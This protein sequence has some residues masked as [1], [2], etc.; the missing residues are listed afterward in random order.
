MSEESAQPSA[1]SFV[2]WVVR[3]PQGVEALLVS[4]VYVAIV[5]VKN[6]SHITDLIPEYKPNQQFYESLPSAFQCLALA[7]ALWLFMKVRGPDALSEKHPLAT[8]ACRQFTVCFTM[9]IGTWIAFYGLVFLW[10]IKRVYGLEPWIDFLNNMQAVF[11]FACYWTLAEITIPDSG[12]GRLEVRESQSISL[13]L[14][15]NYSLW[16]VLVFQLV[17]LWVSRSGWTSCRFW[18]QLAS[19]LAVGVSMAL[20]VGCLESE[21]LKAPGTRASTACLY[22][23][24]VLQLAY[25]GFSPPAE[26]NKS[27][28]LVQYLPVEKYLEGFATITSLP[29]KILFIGLCYW[30]LKEGRL[31]FYME[32]TRRL[33]R[34]APA[35]WNEFCS[36]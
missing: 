28:S 22:G 31:I 36:Q 33:I 19:G 2:G 26:L 3:S 5:A 7:P 16:A 23:Y 32:K 35:E 4:I 14:I 15:L 12:S 21:Y 13:A 11:L 10:E 25:I 1:S 9:L 6:V 27:L 29:L 8:A 20:V 24:T 17:D 34:N 30:A 18:V